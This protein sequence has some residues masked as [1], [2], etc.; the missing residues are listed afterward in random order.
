MFQD[1]PPNN[2]NSRSERFRQGDTIDK[3][4]EAHKRDAEAK[5]RIAEEREEYAK[6]LNA[7][8]A[9]DNGKFVAKHMYRYAGIEDV[10]NNPPDGRLAV[11]KGKRQFFLETIWKLLDKTTKMEILNQ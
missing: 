1:S 5:A 9:S 11:E 6:A 7:I 4:E 2:S 3:I 10:D 8:F